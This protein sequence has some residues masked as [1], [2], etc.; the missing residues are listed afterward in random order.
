MS[1]CNSNSA[2][3]TGEYVSSLKHFAYFKLVRAT[4]YKPEHRD[5]WREAYMIEEGYPSMELDLKCATD[6]VNK[7][8]C[9]GKAEG[10]LT[11]LEGDWLLVLENDDGDELLM[12]IGGRHKTEQA[13][14]YWISTFRDKWL[15]ED[16]SG[17]LTKAIDSL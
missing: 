5:W 1:G 6:L 9:T 17:V 2:I 13:M 14:Y 10:D 8:H 11:R 16:V 15:I 12:L 3:D 4:L 7:K